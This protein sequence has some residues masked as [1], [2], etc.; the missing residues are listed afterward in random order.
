MIPR[1]INALSALTVASAQNTIDLSKDQLDFLHGDDLWLANQRSQA[2]RCVEAVC[3]GALDLLGLPRMQLPAEFIAAT[4]A[5]HVHPAN[6]LVACAI[7]EGAEYS[8]DIINNK[9]EPIS[10]AELFSMVY[11]IQSGNKEFVTNAQKSLVSRAQ[12]QGKA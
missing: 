6:W 7:M 8:E 2:R 10:P 11:Q 4:I 3:Y 1:Y 5:L 12:A 9:Q